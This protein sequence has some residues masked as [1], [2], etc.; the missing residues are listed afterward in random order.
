MECRG[1]LRVPIL[2]KR[3]V[4]R[5]RCWLSSL[6]RSLGVT[7]GSVKPLHGG[8]ISYVV[9]ILSKLGADGVDPIFS[10]P[11]LERAKT[12]HLPAN[13]TFPFS[14][15]FHLRVDILGRVGGAHRRMST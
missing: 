5:L 14:L 10:D 2:S 3:R 7:R 1:F 6:C 15:R 4:I 13:L 12:G 8:S 9:Q 11:W